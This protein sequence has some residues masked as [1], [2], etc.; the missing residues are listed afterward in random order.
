MIHS[1]NLIHPSALIEEDVTIGNGSSIWDNVHI[2][3]GASIGE[4]CIIGEKSYIAY[5]VSI[6]NFVKINAMVYICAHVVIE[7]HA[8][9]S[10]GT[11]FTND[12][13]PRA[14]N[15]EFTALETSSPTEHTLSTVVRQGATIGANAT[16]G[17]GIVIGKFAMIG[18][19]AVVTKDVPDYALVVGNPGK[20]IGYV[21]QCG[22][23]LVKCQDPPKT[24]H[25]QQCNRNYEWSGDALR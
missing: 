8:M 24:I 9:I 20:I 19:G 21:C 7:D 14:M 23:C 15:R 25:C 4:Q 10:A 11:V 1:S 13:F 22:P 5:G 6:G 18:M 2:R 12:R 17:P 16:I 3:H